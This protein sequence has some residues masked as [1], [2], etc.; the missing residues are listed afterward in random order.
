[1]RRIVMQN[2]LAVPEEARLWAPTRQDPRA[3]ENN[4]EAVAGAPW[5]HFHHKTSDMSA[6][7]RG[8]QQGRPLCVEMVCHAC[9][10][11]AIVF[12]RVDLSV[13]PPRTV[14]GDE[15]G[16]VGNEFVQLH[17]TCKPERGVEYEQVCDVRRNGEPK[18]FDF[19]GVRG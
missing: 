17:K 12:F 5:V 18:A 8:K 19:A 6:V 15:V 7:P 10:A 1:M 3:N 16:K 4:V 2:G 11:S 9:H 14:R 13:E